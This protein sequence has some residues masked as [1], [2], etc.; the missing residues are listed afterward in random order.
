MAQPT[1]LDSPDTG[2]NEIDK[3]DAELPLGGEPVD[4]AATANPPPAKKLKTLEVGPRDVSKDGIRW[5]PASTGLVPFVRN[6]ETG[7]V[8]SGRFQMKVVPVG[9]VSLVQCLSGCT[10][11]CGQLL[12]TGESDGCQ[13]L[14]HLLRAY[15]TERQ[16]S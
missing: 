12:C 14:C 6:G 4:V 5:I 11:Q 15:Y 2:T 1:M 13:C 9:S 16:M 3:A 8:H 10:D 7:V